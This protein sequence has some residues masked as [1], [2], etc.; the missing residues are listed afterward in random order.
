LHHKKLN[1]ELIGRIKMLFEMPLRAEDILEYRKVYGVDAPWVHL[2]S[3]DCTR[4]CFLIIEYAKVH[5]LD[6]KNSGNLYL[7]FLAIPDENAARFWM[8]FREQCGDEASKWFHSQNYYDETAVERNP[9]REYI[10]NHLI[11]GE[12]FNPDPSVVGTAVAREVASEVFTRVG[13]VGFRQIN[14]MD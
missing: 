7:F 14:W 5:T 8:S 3:G 12:D 2:S 4:Y 13:R 1:G 10:I 9:I 11:K 6:W